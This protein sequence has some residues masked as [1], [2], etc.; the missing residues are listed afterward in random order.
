MSL[1]LAGRPD[2]RTAK[3]V[4]QT[5]VERG[6][7]L[8]DTADT[9]AIDQTEIGHN[10]VLMA[11]ALAEMGVRPDDGRVVVATKGGRTRHGG[12]WGH[13]AHPDH[14]RAAVHASLRALRAERITLY[15]LHAPDPDIPFEDSVGALADLRAEG[16]IDAVGLSNVDIGEIERAR[17]LVPVASVQ[18]AQSI[19]D[20]G[21][22]RSPVVSYCLRHDIVFLAYSP[23]GG[24]GRAPQLAAN[25]ALRSLSDQLHV[26]VHQ[27]A[28]SWLLHEAPNVV[29]VVGAS[30]PDR[31][32]SNVGALSMV[33]DR[34][35]R[36]RVRAAAH[37]LPGHDGPLTR[38]RKK[39]S[40]QMGRRGAP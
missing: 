20:T 24:S 13:N 37:T 21:Y 38:L 7:T 34:R 9:Y 35:T 33:L 15:Q 4:I 11:E 23:L 1:S 17:A 19:W 26:S 10:E 14:L 36:R 16:K 31:I 25:A 5:A 30:R 29:A 39:V 8:L 12:V 2:R 27:L 32:E 6:L 28:V 40:R 3:R 22:R 18:N